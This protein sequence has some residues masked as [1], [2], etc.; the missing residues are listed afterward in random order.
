MRTTISNAAVLLAICLGI[1][2]ATTVGDIREV[3]TRPVGQG[4]SGKVYFLQ[5]SPMW[6]VKQAEPTKVYFFIFVLD[7]DEIDGAAQSFAANFFVMVRWLDRRLA[8]PN[9]S[10]LRK[11]PIDEIWNPGIIVAN[12]QGIIRT[13][14]PE[15]ADVDS[16]G[17]VVYRQRYVGALSEPLDLSRFPLDQHVFTIQMIAVGHEPHDLEFLPDTISRGRAPIKAGGISEELSL[18]DWEILTHAAISHPYEPMPGIYVDGFAFQ[19]TAKRNFPYYLFQVIVPL[20]V[21][22]GMS[23]AAFWIDPSQTGAQIGVATSAI[24]S[25]IAFKFVLSGLLPKLPYMTRMDY[26]MLGSTL[27]VF[28]AMGEVVV[29]SML[30]HGGKNLLARRLD[31]VARVTFPAMFLTILLVSMLA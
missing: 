1:C 26:F 14:L 5:E 30:S 28:F 17:T 12:Q 2:V 8:D 13:S 6:P 15:V 23:W 27:L 16:K 29:T 22:V 9:S 11:V 4:E 10:G 7:I 21:V 25:L 20:A 19:F 24:L 3:A 31:R 18:P